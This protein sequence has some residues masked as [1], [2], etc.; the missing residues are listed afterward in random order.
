MLAEAFSPFAHGLPGHAESLADDLVLKSLGGEKDK[1]GADD[2]GVR[3]RVASGCRFE[4]RSLLHREN[5]NVRAHLGHVH[6]SQGVV[7]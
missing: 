6:L 5:H 2:M 1:L 3:S 4:A 7:R